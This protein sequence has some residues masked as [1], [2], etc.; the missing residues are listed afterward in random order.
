MLRR[1]FFAALLTASAAQGAP[2]AQGRTEWKQRIGDCRIT[3][4]TNCPDA[5]A[6]VGDAIDITISVE[7]PH[8][9]YCRIT[10]YQDG[11]KQGKVRCIEFG[12]TAELSFKAS[13]PG[14]VSAV[15]ALLDGDKR[16]IARP[17]KRKAF[18]YFGVIIDPEKLAPGNPIPPEDFDRFWAQ[19]RAE[20]DLVPVKATRR[21]VPLPDRE[22]KKY[23]DV[24]CHD[25]KVDCAGDAPVSG[26]LCM[27]RGAKPKTLPAIVHFHGAG[28]RS[29]KPYPTYGQTAIAFD[30]NAHGIENGKP[31]SYYNEL[32]ATGRLKDYRLASWGDHRSN[33]FVGM[34]VRIMRALDYVKTLPE[35][36]GKTLVVYGGSQ[37]GAQAIAAA[38]LD[39]RVT[40]CVSHVPSL[41]D[42]GAGAVARRPGGP[43]PSLP[44][45]KQRDPEL[46]REAA[47]VDLVF[48]AGR[49]KCP[50]YLAVG[51][52]DNIC[53]AT[54]SYIFYN[55]LPE[56]TFKRIAVWPN[57]G[58]TGPHSIQGKS[59]IRKALK[60]K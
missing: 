34:F 9:G 56:S 52:G 2:S 40:L 55:A 6:K 53:I 59:A 1:L 31:E 30:I 24:V 25:V 47:Y 14:S 38:A 27:P 22:A 11:I 48:F 19:K 51:L 28:V 3:V 35:W 49:I 36:D 16:P 58:H 46:I 10:A 45:E 37:G 41:C 32:Y 43:L 26:Y 17:G 12:K 29:A 7:S 5:R 13:R 4:R 8:P 50:L 54:S 60:M 20:L 33:Y 15:C 21:E 57:L 39:D 42:L 44:V 18:V 23:P